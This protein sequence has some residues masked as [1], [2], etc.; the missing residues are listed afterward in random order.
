MLLKQSAE[1]VVRGFVLLLL[2]NEFFMLAAVLVD[3]MVVLV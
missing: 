1:V 2:D 3:R